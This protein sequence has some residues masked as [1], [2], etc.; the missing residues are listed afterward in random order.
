MQEPNTT[1][2]EDDKQWFLTLKRKIKRLPWRAFLRMCGGF[3]K[4]RL[5]PAGCIV[6]CLLLLVTGSAATIS[7]AVCDKTEDRIVTVEALNGTD[8]AFDCILVLGCRVYGDGRIS[9]MLEDRVKTAVGL[10]QAGL[11]NRILMSGDSQ[12]EHY[13][14][15]GAMRR[16]AE[17][18]GVPSDAIETDPY[19]LSTY[20]SVARFAQNGGGR[21]LIVT[22]SYHLYRALYIAERF[23]LEAFG[24]SADL[25]RYTGQLKRDV[26]E[27]F[28]RCKDV[29][30][31]QVKPSVA[32]TDE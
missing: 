32:K 6:L 9:H 26:R 19:G 5:L 31:S 22:Q 2:R 10:Y 15:V 8:Q 27:V 20:E 29:Y 3:S 13:D 17:Q 7:A 24:V 1:E 14:E 16:Y 23:G 12:T 30:L 28:A 11:G 4:R 18:L 21:V 25:R